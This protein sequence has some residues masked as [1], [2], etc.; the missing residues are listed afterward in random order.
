MFY[1][2][3]IFFKGFHAGKYCRYEKTIGIYSKDKGMNFW[4]FLCHG[5]KFKSIEHLRGTEKTV[6]KN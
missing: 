6:E 2:G 1:K 5:S 3:G 4:N